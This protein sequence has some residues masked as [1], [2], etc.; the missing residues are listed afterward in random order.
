MEQALERM[1]GLIGTAI[2]WVQLAAWLPADWRDAPERRRSATAASFAAALE[3]V[4]AGRLDLRQD[5]AFEPIYLRQRDGE[6]A[7]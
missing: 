7:R 4:K 6:D 1:R 2:D 3:L 5:A